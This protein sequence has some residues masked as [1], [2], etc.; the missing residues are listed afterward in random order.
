MLEAGI[1]KV[2]HQINYTQEDEAKIK[3]IMQRVGL[4]SSQISNYN[5][6]I[7]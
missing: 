5:I 1:C 4:N 6:F 2:G 7:H 3:Q